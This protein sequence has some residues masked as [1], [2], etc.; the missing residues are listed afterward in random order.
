[1]LKRLEGLAPHNFMT[2]IA[3]GCQV[4]VPDP[5]L[6]YYNPGA[7]CY[8]VRPTKWCSGWDLNPHYTDSK[9]VDSAVGLPKQV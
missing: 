4:R 5:Y 7:N 9:S 8:W 3:D 2:E 6:D 1:M